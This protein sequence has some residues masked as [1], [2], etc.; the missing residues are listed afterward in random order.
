MLPHPPTTTTAYNTISK[1]D[2]GALMIPVFPSP[3]SPPSSEFLLAT[4]LRE[5]LKKHLGMSCNSQTWQDISKSCIEPGTYQHKTDLLLSSV[6]PVMRKPDSE[7]EKRD[8]YSLLGPESIQLIMQPFMMQSTSKK[9]LV[10]QENSRECEHTDIT[11]DWEGGGG[12]KHCLCLRLSCDLH[13]AG[14]FWETELHL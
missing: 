2:V 14:C 9:L 13:K 6:K 12:R 1:W 3:L 7:K 4:Y 8:F 5:I 10:Q 11:L